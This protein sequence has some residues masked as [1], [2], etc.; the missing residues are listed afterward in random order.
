MIKLGIKSSA[1]NQPCNENN[2]TMMTSLN[3]NVF[4]VTGPLCGKYTG[5]RWIHLTKVSD[6]QLWCFLWFAPKRLSIQSR[7][8]WF[9]TPSH[10]LWRQLYTNNMV[11]DGNC[12]P[13]ITLH[14]INMLKP[15]KIGHHL[16]DEIFQMHFR[17]WKSWYFADSKTCY[18]T[19][20]WLWSHLL[21]PAHIQII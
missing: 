18:K 4:R 14:Y 17:E 11:F 7:L 3:G 9:E 5:L 1:K 10:S 15:E 13:M 6:A 21:H 2:K 12:M 20:I 19:L 8:R 16:A